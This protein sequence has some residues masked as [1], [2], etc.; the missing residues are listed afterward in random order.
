MTNLLFNRLTAIGNRLAMVLT[1]FVVVGIGQ[2]WGATTNYTF[3]SAKWADSSN[4]WTSGKDGAGYSNSGVQVTKNGTG[5][6]ATSK[7]SFTNISAISVNYCTNKSSGAGTIVLTVGSTSK[8]LTVSSSGGTTMRVLSTSFDTNVSGTVKITVNCTENS[9]Y[10]GGITITTEEVASCTEPTITFSNGSYTIGGSVLD[11]STLFDSNSNGAVTYSVTNANGTGATISGSNFTATATGSAKVSATQAAAGSYCA[12]SATATITVT[13]QQTTITLSEAGQ[14]SNP[15]GTFYVGDM[16]QLPSTTKA[17]CGDKTFV[18]WSTVEIDNSAEK[19]T[20]NFHERGASVTLGATNTFYAVFAETGG[21]PTTT[22]PKTEIANIK[23]TDEVVITMSNGVT[24][25]A[26]RN[27][28]GTSAAP[29]AESITIT[30]EQIS[31]KVGDVQIWNISNS[32]G[33]LTI[34]PKGG[35]STWLYCTNTNNGVRVG[36]NENKTFTISGNYL[37]NTATSRYVGVYVTNP[38]WRCYDNTAGNIAGQTLAFYAKTTTT[39]YQNYT[40]SCS[41]QTRRSLTY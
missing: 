31:S 20:S 25:W 39:G 34:Y 24:T 15:S 7:T 18:G 41:T 17:T 14:T 2:A 30:N 1:M 19:P 40:T 4:G 33:N 27:D 28:D 8:T 36:T 11:L 32:S 38:D 10:V 6:Y 12:G 26:L 3:T 13:K 22:W 5:A 37:K 9:I 21:T 23:S 16:Y 29:Y 35:T